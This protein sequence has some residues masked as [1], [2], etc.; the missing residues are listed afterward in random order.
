[1]W[2]TRPVLKLDERLLTPWTS[3]PSARR[4]SARYDPS[5]PVIPVIKA[6]FMVVR[7]NLGVRE[8]YLDLIVESRTG[9]G[10]V[11]CISGTVSTDVAVPSQGET[12]TPAQRP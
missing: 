5:W 8:S 9:T 4:N 10:I 1:M 12:A 6:F 11:D 7:W 2:S 3:Y